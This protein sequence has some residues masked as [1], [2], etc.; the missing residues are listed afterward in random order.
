M[1]PMG[2]ASAKPAQVALSFGVT[3]GAVT[4][5]FSLGLTWDSNCL[6]FYGLQLLTTG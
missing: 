2:S 3:T 5:G 6:Q 4:W 1:E